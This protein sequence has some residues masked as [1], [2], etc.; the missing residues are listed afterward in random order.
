M[1]RVKTSTCESLR[2]RTGGALA[3]TVAPGLPAGAGS[4]WLSDFLSGETFGPTL[5]SISTFSWLRNQKPLL[6][7][8]GGGSISLTPLPSMRAF[9]RGRSS[10]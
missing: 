1:S 7:K 2:G 4:H 6:S 9:I 5:I 8:P 10:A 3:R